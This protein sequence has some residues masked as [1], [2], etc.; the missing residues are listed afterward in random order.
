MIDPLPSWDQ[1]YRNYVLANVARTVRA[2][3]LEEVQRQREIA[4]LEGM[5]GEGK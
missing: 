5:W 1:F 2:E 4:E 3:M